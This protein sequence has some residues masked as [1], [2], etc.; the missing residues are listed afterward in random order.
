MASH[1]F[2]WA[3]SGAGVCKIGEPQGVAGDVS[4]VSPKGCSLPFLGVMLLHQANAQAQKAVEPS[5][6]VCSEQKAVID[7]CATHSQQY[8][9]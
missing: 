1:Q 9:Q 2:L 5:H 7:L 8:S 4:D 6:P 3:H